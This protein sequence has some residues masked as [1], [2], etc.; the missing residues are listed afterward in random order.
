MAFS[1][2]RD[3]PQDEQKFRK[4]Y[5][6]QAAELGLDPNPDDP[7]HF[8]DWRAAYRSGAAADT[9]GHWPSEFKHPLHPRRV[10]SGVD[11]ATGEAKPWIT[12]VEGMPRD[13]TRTRKKKR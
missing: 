9:A 5:A 10:V 4:W 8:Y 7:R 1:K 13:A 6:R 2:H 11:T 3:P 12:A